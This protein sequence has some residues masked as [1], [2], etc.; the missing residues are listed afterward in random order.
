[1]VPQT[2]QSAVSQGF[3][4]AN[5]PRC[6]RSRAFPRPADLEIGD[7]ADWEV[8]GTVRGVLTHF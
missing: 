6:P 5:H 2:S 3:Q 8:C 1:M 4:P 7:T